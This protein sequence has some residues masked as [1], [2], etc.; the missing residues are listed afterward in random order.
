MQTKTDTDTKTV[1]DTN[2]HTQTHRHRQTYKQRQRQ[3][4]TRALPPKWDGD[5]QSDPLKKEVSNM[6]SAMSRV[7]GLVNEK[8]SRF[9]TAPNFP[10]RKMD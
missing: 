3:R 1:T 4:H 5:Q 10:S 9:G 2:P 7:Q 8:L 6:G